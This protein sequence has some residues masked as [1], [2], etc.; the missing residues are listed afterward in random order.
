MALS[1][2]VV[3]VVA[4]AVSAPGVLLAAAAC[5]YILHSLATDAWYREWFASY[6]VTMAALYVAFA[7][8][9]IATACLATR[10]TRSA[11]AMSLAAL[12]FAA[13]CALDFELHDEAERVLPF[14]LLFGPYVAW[15][16]AW[17]ALRSR[18]AP[19][20]AAQ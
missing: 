5:V 3:I 2:R 16:L 12:G 10:G 9:V 7:A 14:G 8:G 17:L 11:I 15:A 6:G 19:A 20:A 4:S 18:P 13:A 1:R